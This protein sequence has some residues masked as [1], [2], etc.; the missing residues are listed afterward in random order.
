MNDTNT[1]SASD[2]IVARGREERAQKMSQG[3]DPA[4]E[5]PKMQ[6]TGKTQKETRAQYLKRCAEHRINSNII[7]ND[8]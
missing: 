8:D 6:L 7:K 5:V 3:L 1:Q 2:R 4:E